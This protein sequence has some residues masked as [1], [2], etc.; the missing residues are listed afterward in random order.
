MEEKIDIII[1]AYKAHKTLTRTLA[2]I[3]VQRGVENFKITIVND[4]CPEGNYQDIIK[5]FL[6]IMDIQEIILKK[7]SGPGVARQTG[8]NKTHNPYIMFVDADDLLAHPYSVS[9]L[10]KDFKESAATGLCS[11]TFMEKASV[12]LQDGV[13]KESDVPH[14]EDMTWCFSKIYSRDFLNKYYIQFPATRGNEDAIFNFMCGVINNL[15]EKNAIAISEILTYIWCNDRDDSI[16]RI[17]DHQY[18]F[19]Q[20]LCGLVDGLIFTLPWLKK[21]HIKKQK[22]TSD[23]LNWFFMFY[24]DYN[25]T[26]QDEKA[27]VFESQCW[28][29]IKKYYWAVLHDVWSEITLNQIQEAYDNRMSSDYAR[30]ENGLVPQRAGRVPFMTIWE[31]V[32][33]IEK[34]GYHPEELDAILQALPE[35][36][37]QSNLQCGAVDPDHYNKKS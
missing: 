11:G 1:P 6:S 13:V 5:P 37:K 12:T 8:I 16:T 28:F 20:S 21:N 7:N 19:D 9:L 18:T 3:A 15:K 32:D 26:L 2:S 23:Y 31:F 33:R 30:T 27:K 25:A 24:N 17:N 29:Y 4:C 22:V 10:F 36:V 34:E 14:N 35:K